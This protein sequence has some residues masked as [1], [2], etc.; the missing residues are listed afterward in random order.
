M[1][2]S[3]GNILFLK[4]KKMEF[5]SVPVVDTWRAME[6][7]GQNHYYACWDVSMHAVYMRLLLYKYEVPPLTRFSKS[8]FKVFSWK[9]IFLGIFWCSFR[10]LKTY[11]EKKDLWVRTFKG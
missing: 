10:G 9:T 2:I 4:D 1:S 3:A 6:S 8:F 5:A 11:S 7:L